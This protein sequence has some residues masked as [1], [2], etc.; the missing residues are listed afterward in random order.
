MSQ[1]K[2][3]RL[4]ITYQSLYIQYKERADTYR[5]I[6]GRDVQVYSDLVARI[7]LERA[8]YYE[9]IAEGVR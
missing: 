5:R 2:A 3:K 6:A 8:N 1:H 7:A 4:F 9:M